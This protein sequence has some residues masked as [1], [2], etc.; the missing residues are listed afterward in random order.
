MEGETTDLI[1]T[2]RGMR[3]GC[4]LSTVLFNLYSAYI[5]KET[6]G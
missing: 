3:Q 2:R 6:L 5:F 4:I 1:E